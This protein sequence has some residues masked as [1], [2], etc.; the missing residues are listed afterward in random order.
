MRESK[1]ELLDKHYLSNKK[2]RLNSGHKTKIRDINKLFLQYN[3]LNEADILPHD[4]Y[5]FP[6]D[7]YFPFYFLP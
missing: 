5:K 7:I 4:I 3:F 6:L 1:E 2:K